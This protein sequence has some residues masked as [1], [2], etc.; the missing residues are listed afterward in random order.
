M[1]PVKV[2]CF[3]DMTSQEKLNFVIRSHGLDIDSIHDNRILSQMTD[4][5]LA[6]PVNMEKALVRILQEQY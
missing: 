5:D 1:E 6:S 3:K 2:K 4:E